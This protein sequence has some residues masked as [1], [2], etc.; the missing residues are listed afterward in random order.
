MINLKNSSSV[1]QRRFFQ[2]LL[3]E[4]GVQGGPRS[5][6]GQSGAMAGLAEA[7][8]R[9]ACLKVS[10]MRLQ[11]VTVLTGQLSTADSHI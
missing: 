5:E 7:L 3:N 4:T 2:N 6:T 8:A 1:D 10:S 9:G 11:V